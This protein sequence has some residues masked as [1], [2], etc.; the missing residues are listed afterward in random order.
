MSEFGDLEDLALLMF[1]MMDLR[2]L[3]WLLW[4]VVVCG[5]AVIVRYAHIHVPGVF[6]GATSICGQTSSPALAITGG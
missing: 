6:T 1:G 3:F 4:F 5:G 2:L